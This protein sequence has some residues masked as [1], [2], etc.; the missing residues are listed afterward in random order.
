[1]GDRFKMEGTYTYLGLIHVD[2]WQKPT[3]YCKTIILPLK[4]NKFKLNYKKKERKTV[5]AI[6]DLDG[7]HEPMKVIGL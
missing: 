7:G 4:T 6:A 3:Q 2:V 1:M 5:P